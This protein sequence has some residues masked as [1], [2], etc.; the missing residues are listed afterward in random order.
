MGTGIE[1]NKTIDCFAS[2]CRNG[3]MHC[4]VLKYNEFK[5][6]LNHGECGTDQCPFFKTKLQHEKDV[7]HA[8]AIRA[9]K[10][11]L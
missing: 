7:R 5:K 11:I 2:A 8:R 6:Y 1:N 10:G 4:D 3:V 9:E